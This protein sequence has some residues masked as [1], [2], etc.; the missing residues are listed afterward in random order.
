[1]S[2]A[3][4]PFH[5][6]IPVDDLSVAEDFY[7]GV[8]GLPRGRSSD[9]WTD[10]DFFGH[11][12]VT[13]LAPDECARAP[14]NDVDGHAVPVRHFGVVLD[15]QS[16]LALAERLRARRIDFLIEPGIRFEGQAGEQGT[17]FVCDPAGNALEFKYFDDPEQLFASD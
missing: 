1:M 7:G 2:K 5:L 6:A 17:F 13:H 10:Y 14:T 8:L 12:L 9:Q 4:H 16:W 11:Q 3:L 15:K